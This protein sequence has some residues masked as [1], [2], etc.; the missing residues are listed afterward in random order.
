MK[1]FKKA[2]RI[3]GIFLMLIMVTTLFSA[4]SDNLGEQL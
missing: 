3:L 1:V 2:K 4:C